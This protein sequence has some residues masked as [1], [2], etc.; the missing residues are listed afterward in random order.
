MIGNYVYSF[1]GDFSSENI[2]IWLVF[3]GLITVFNIVFMPQMMNLRAYFAIRNAKGSLERL[4]DW[5]KESKRVVLE[6]LKGYGRSLS[7]LEQ[8][9]DNFREFFTI[10]PVS[11]DPRGVLD[12]MEHILDV[13][14]MRYEDK[15][16]KFAPEADERELA[17]LEMTL[18]GAASNYALFK[19][20]RHYI[21]VAEKTKSMQIAQLLQMQ[22]PMLEKMAES[23]NDATKA[24]ADS[25]VIGDGIGPLVATE[26]IAD[27][28]TEEKI[29][30]TVHSKIEVEDRDAYV[31]KAKGPGGRVGKPG[32][33]VKELA[34]NNELDRI[35]MID[36]S[37]KLEGE[38]SG[39]VVEGVGAAIGGPP[40]EKHKI[41]ELATE[42]DI[43]VD[44]IV[45]KESIREA[46][47][48]MKRD[49][50]ESVD[51]TINKLK[52]AIRE[53]TSEDEVILIAGIGNTIG[54]GQDK[55]S[56]PS[57]FPEKE[58]EEKEELE[59]SFN[60]PGMGGI[61]GSTGFV[62]SGILRRMRNIL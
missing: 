54:V 53:R 18:E 20:V 36:A 51:E 33:L 28:D 19:I 17:D 45:V 15:V 56:L 16:E 26:L 44:A 46:I 43:P 62:F 60:L 7:D 25:E 37:S 52:K 48:S 40:T 1:I 61:A 41:E 22:L 39:K 6:K 2:L 4:D 57:E 10:D 31:V 38:K 32:E 27:A 14:K 13:R 59:S 5:S 9:F 8:E 21:Q 47:T 3:M 55:D 34:E 11:D 29:K 49:L 50:S 12:R 42:K 23:Y 24:F 30:D 58:E 35:F